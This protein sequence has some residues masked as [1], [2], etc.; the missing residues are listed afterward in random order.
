MPTETEDL[1]PQKRSRSRI[2]QACIPCHRSKRKCNRKKPCSQ[3]LKR[4]TTKDCTYEALAA[5]DLEILEG[6]TTSVDAENRIL[7]SRITQLEA[8]ITQLRDRNTDPVDSRKRRRTPEKAHD[9]D[10]VYYG[11]SFYLGGPAAPDLLHRM[12]ALLPNQPSDL[13][14]AFVGGTDSSIP[15]RNEGGSILP[16]G[17]LMDCGVDDLCACLRNISPESL[18]AILDSFVDIVDPLHHYLPMPWVLQRYERCM[19][20]AVTP[21]PQEAALVFA[22]LGLGNL[23]AANPTSFNF[24]SASFQLLRLSNFLTSPSIDSI[25]TFC[26]IAV[27]LQHEGKLNEYWPLLG[28]VIRLAQS[29]G[30][31]R[32]PSLISSLDPAEGEIRRRLFHAIV[33]QETALSVM[34][35]RPN[36]LG[37]FD[38]ALPRDISDAELFGVKGP[39]TVHP[40]E[41]SYNRYAWELM[42]ITRD[43]VTSSL[44]TPKSSTLAREKSISQQLRQWHQRLPA[45]LSFQ[46]PGLALQD[47]NDQEEQVHY[48][49]ALILHII[50]NHNVLVLYRRPLLS[51]SHPE[52][53]EP[54]IEAAIAVAE[55]W[56]ILQ[57]SFPKIA[58][59]AWMQWFRA[60]H[61]ALI[62]LVALRARETKS[63]LKV[64]A[65]NSWKSCIRIF[66]RIQDQNDSIQCCWRAL[67]RLDDVAKRTVNI[68]RRLPAQGLLR[69]DIQDTSSVL[70]IGP[71]AN[72]E[73]SSDENS[74]SPPAPSAGPETDAADRFFPEANGQSSLTQAMS[75]SSQETYHIDGFDPEY[76]DLLLGCGQDFDSYM[77]QVTVPGEA[78]GMQTLADSAQYNIFD[79]DVA[80]WP[81]WLTADQ[82]AMGQAE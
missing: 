2:I 28:M 26:F 66:S 36:G 23:V 31:H 53:A 59:I 70:R 8:V 14:F 6:G 82:T 12:M 37:F 55:G 81:F 60:F 75:T 20:I 19:N 15:G 58:R 29:M 39:A 72:Q 65:F 44:T 63:H 25:A 49:Q 68:R 38:C 21:E 61:A 42:E 46:L 51:D 24:I 41:I 48:V 9:Q 54:C 50:V 4:Q 64:R 43:L 45:S 76:N 22:V 27:Y 3:C 56:K 16:I 57:D 78:L 17:N 35:G 79:L 73:F 71:S 18:D 80:N 62:C 77:T 40:H 13:F 10:G 74:N 69:R 1:P 34:F 67:S 7:R 5:E 33:G 32:D 52:A 11:R 30:L 47:F